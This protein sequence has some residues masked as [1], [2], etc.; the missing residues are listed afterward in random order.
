MKIFTKYNMIE[1]RIKIKR[2]MPIKIKKIKIRVEIK[3]KLEL[4]I[5]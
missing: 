4:R 1:I 5:K 3:R 2:W